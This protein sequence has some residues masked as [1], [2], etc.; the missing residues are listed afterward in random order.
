MLASLQPCKKNHPN[1]VSCSGQNFNE[2]DIDASDF[3][4][5]FKCKDV[6][7]FGKLNNLYDNIF[8]S[9]FHPDYNK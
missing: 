1:V 2:I 3:T 6:H 8:Q 4:N 5:G 9:S 7:I